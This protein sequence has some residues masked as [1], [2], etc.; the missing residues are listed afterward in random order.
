MAK[1][2]SNE[3]WKEANEVFREVDV[4]KS[5]KH[6]A[7]V[8]ARR[9]IEERKANRDLEKLIQEFDWDDI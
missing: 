9:K 2:V 3:V 4:D 7:D 5:I 1:G 6:H 8:D